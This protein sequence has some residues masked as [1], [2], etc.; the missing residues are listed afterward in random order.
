[1]HFSATRVPMGILPGKCREG[2]V[3]LL[4][5]WNNAGSAGWV[6]LHREPMHTRIGT[7]M[8]GHSF[9]VL[10]AVVWTACAQV[11]CW[12]STLLTLLPHGARPCPSH[13]DMPA[14]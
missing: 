4:S 13:A 6:W 11:A 14:V 10:V 12:Q 5:P 2:D 9:V 3:L 8:A 7:S 1:M